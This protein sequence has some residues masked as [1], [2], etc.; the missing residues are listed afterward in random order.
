[1]TYHIKQK[2][3]TY[4]LRDAYWENKGRTC[5]KPDFM[6]SW[7]GCTMIAAAIVILTVVIGG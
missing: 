7:A 4:R 5:D 1:M 2:P 3:M 6:N